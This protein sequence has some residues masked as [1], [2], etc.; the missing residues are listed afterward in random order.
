MR[1][2]VDALRARLI[3]EKTQQSETVEISGKAL[4]I[5]LGFDAASFIDYQVMATASWVDSSRTAIPG[6]KPRIR[7]KGEMVRATIR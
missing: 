4:D 1:L 6:A 5:H 3:Y 7:I 2:D